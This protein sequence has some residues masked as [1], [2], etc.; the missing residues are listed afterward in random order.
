MKRSATIKVY[1]QALGGHFL[2]PHA[3]QTNNIHITLLFQGKMI[4]LPYHLE[5]DA[6]DGTPSAFDDGVTTFS[7]IITIPM[8]NQTVPT[9]NYLKPNDKT[10]HGKATIDLPGVI[11]TCDLVVNIPV[12]SSQ[13]FTMRQQVILD[14]SI[15]N[16]RIVMIVPGLYLAPSSIPGFVS[17][18]VRMMCGCPVTPG[19]PASLWPAKDFT[20][21]A[22]VVDTSG[23][24]TPYELFY[25][26]QQQTNSLF[27]A[28][29]H[30]GQKPVK[31]IRFTARQTSTG[32]YGVL[33]Q[34]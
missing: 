8:S 7:P 30:P 19:P 1:L 2:G 25:Q 26:M 13:P 24:V 23:G 14:P 4:N 17:V 31:S 12:P 3:Y 11:T 32:N 9:I 27:S 29:L 10:I 6:N 22:E 21:T 28:A 33:M 34:P 18:Y 15:N 16:Y 5:S 20:V